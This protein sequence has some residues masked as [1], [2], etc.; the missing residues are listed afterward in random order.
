[1]EDLVDLTLVAVD[2]VVQ[3]VELEFL[4]FCH[5]KVDNLTSML[6]HKEIMVLL[7]LL[8]AK[9]VALVV[10]LLLEMVVMVVLIV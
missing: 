3:V 9:L 5:L 6:A 2:V 10:N 7:D 1:M 8:V 4:K